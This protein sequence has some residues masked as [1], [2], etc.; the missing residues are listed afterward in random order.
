LAASDDMATQPGTAVHRTAEES[1][2]R[3]NITWS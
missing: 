1:G 3:V 2:S